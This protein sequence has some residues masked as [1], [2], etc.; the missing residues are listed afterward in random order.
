M[1]DYPIRVLLIDDDEDD[2]II[3]RDLLAEIGG[4]RFEL[5]WVATY[6]AGLEAIGRHQHDIYLLDYHLGQGNGLA[7]LREAVNNG[8]TVPM[9]L[10]TGQGDHE[11]DIEAMK[12]GA[13]DFLIKGRIEASALE[14]S[15]R[16]AI[17]RARLF[18]ETRAAC[19]Q[20]E[21]RVREM[22][23]LQKMSRA[24]SGTLD[25]NQ[26][27]DALVNALSQEMGYTYIALNLMDEDTNEIRTVRAAGLAQGLDGLVRSLDEMEGDILVDVARKG[28]IEVTDG[29]DERFDREIY[30]REGHEA[31]VRAFVPLLLRD[32]PVGVL[33]VGYRRD[34]RPVISDEEIR[35]LGGL[36]DQVAV[37]LSNASLFAAEARRRQE[38]ETLSQ[39]A[40][41]LSATLN[42]QQVFELILSQLKQVVPYDSA[43][44]QLLKGG[45]LEIIGGVGFSNFDEL[46]G[47]SF[48][49]DGDNP[50]CAV[51]A[52]RAPF[53]VEDA[54]AVYE[55]FRRE[56]HAHTLIRSWLGVPLL[57]GDRLIGMVTLDKREPG[58]Y[59]EEYARLALAFAA[60]AAIAIENARLYEELYEAKVTA[61]A[62]TQAK[63][64]FLANMSHEI[65]TPLNAVI[66]M[67]GLLLDTELTSEQLDFVETIRASGDDLLTLINDILD[68]SKI[69][70]GKLELEQQPFDLRDC[71]EGSLD[72]LGP[73]SAEKGLELA[74]LVEDNTP[75]TL[76]GDV[77][78]LRQILVNL[79]SN[80][81]KFTET[82][83]VV[84]SVTGRRLTENRHHEVHFA[85]RDTGIGIPQERMDRLFQSFSQ[86]DA[87]TTRRYGG[88]GLG[89]AISKRLAE[90]MGG[91]MW[92]ESEVGKGST[93][94][95]TI[96]TEAAPAP[97]RVYLRGPEPQLTGKRLLIVDDN[98][99]NRR[100]LT[101]QAESWGMLPRAAGSGAQALD[102][103]CRGDPFDVAILDMR[104]P[105]MDGLTLA[106]EICERR[107]E[108]EL[109]LVM[110][111]S[112]GQHEEAAQGV[113]FAAYLT[114]P[115]KSSQ[116]YDM[117]MGIFAGQPSR[118]RETV[119][120]LQ[121][122][123]EMGCRHPLHILLAE[124]NVVNQKVALRILERMGYR[125]DLAANGLEVLEALERQHY[126]VVLMDVQMPEM[127]GEEATRQI[128]KRWPD[129]GRP[130]IVAMTAHAL[131][132][133]RE[134]YLGAG[135]DDYISKPVRVEE[136]AEALERCQP[137][138]EH[139]DGQLAAGE[140]MAQ[141]TG[142][143][144]DATAM[145]KFRAMIGED[146]PMFLA[147]LITAFHDDS[148]KLLAEMREAVVK[149]DA[150]SLQRAAHTLKGSSAT[151]GAMRLS[152]MCKELELMGHEGILEGVAEKVAQVEAEYGRVKVALE[153]G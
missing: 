85:V 52:T 90:M 88:T 96:V 107:D 91:R 71:I 56:P 89:L 19:Q 42:L 83:E 105:E 135:M 112:M 121:F 50:N 79:L 153:T 29:W 40:Q 92:V 58:F 98:E 73:K 70:S 17:E 35:L 3:T 148:I 95:F 141:A 82:G 84:V 125:A 60:Q 152:A 23:I 55:A 22:Q 86:V 11:V 147:E 119:S 39:A 137:V 61:E 133:D 134:R 139:T 77:T 21:A 53:I 45:C 48:P 130:W 76:M 2:C 47:F 78:R 136:L 14:R 74:Y 129:G 81:V 75:S 33:E 32:K 6:D 66:G 46:L 63:S 150:V 109:P 101:K 15:I 87:S 31:L 4:G 116:L 69:E 36:A 25:L 13:A 41:A 123:S 1:D 37:A 149:G 51:I 127:D 62:A 131:S 65:R 49:A 103:I 126:D 59:T 138:G 24:I 26:V 7:L 10:L 54:P 145:E 9:I 27:L 93:F 128:H 108:R 117:L 120:R 122:D 8:C 12:A 30:E 68:F 143:A 18:E 118:A 28:E 57:F 114:K 94:H 144:I 100:I 140:T 151:L 38:A 102:W 5:E 99:T 124:D 20:A 113:E 104:M 64:E 111:T 72:L 110:L 34:E 97:K 146:A 132:G 115:V 67:T 43:S 44:V 80:A 16:Y 142:G 106:A